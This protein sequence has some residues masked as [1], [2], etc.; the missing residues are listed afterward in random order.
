MVF[1]FPETSEQHFAYIFFEKTIFLKYRC[2]TFIELIRDVICTYYVFNV[3]YPKGISQSL[4]FFVRFF[5]KYYPEN[6]R[7][8]KNHINNLSK[9]NHLITRLRDLKK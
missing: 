9:I 2:F 4:E 5:W 7:G 1:F 8:K 3:M 6:L